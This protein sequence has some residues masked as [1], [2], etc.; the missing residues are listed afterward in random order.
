MARARN[1]KPGF[2]KNPELVECSVWARLVFPGLWMLADR[3]GRLEDR[4]KQ[5]K[6]ELL[7][8][9]PQDMDP[10]LQEL[11][12][13]GFI[14]RYRNEDGAFIQITRFAAHQ[15]PHFSEKASCI[16]PPD[17]EKV[18]PS[19]AMDSGKVV[20]LKEGENARTP[21]VQ[22][23]DCLNPSS[24]TPSSLIVGKDKPKV[25]KQSPHQR[26]PAAPVV[27]IAALCA[28]GLAADLAAEYIALRARKR[29]PL[30]ARAWSGIAA[31]IGKA[32]LSLDDG[33]AKALQRGWVGFE[34]EWCKPNGVVSFH[35]QKAADMQKWMTPGQPSFDYIDAENPN[36][37]LAIR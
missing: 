16:K 2:Y 14:Q 20:V 34:A 21:E 8:A 12:A 23:P 36:D 26:A 24:L 19:S 4:P 35:D 29:A 28:E 6:M 10:L 15:S 5:I 27:T 17:S 30:S 7:P 32:G 33:I 22:P 25:Q 31:E 3:E 1:I 13:H 9:D 18:A 11:A 37:P